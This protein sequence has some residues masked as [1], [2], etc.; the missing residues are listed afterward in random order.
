MRTDEKALA[1]LQGAVA[2]GR[3]RNELPAS[4]G[5]AAYPFVIDSSADSVGSF[6]ARGAS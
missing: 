6:C 5:L 1:S 3:Q 2:V 4:P